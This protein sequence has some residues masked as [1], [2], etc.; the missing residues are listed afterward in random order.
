MIKSDW[1]YV[2][3]IFGAVLTSGVVVCLAIEGEFDAAAIVVPFVILIC[4][5][6]VMLIARNNSFL[7]RVMIAG[8]V[9]K[10]F[11]AWVYTAQASFEGT[12]ARWVYFETARQFSTSAI[13]MAYFFPLHHLWGTDL[14]IFIASHLFLL[15]GPSLAAAMVLFAMVSFW[16][17]FL[18]YCAFVKAFPA[19]DRR[20][21]AL[22]TFLFPSVVYWTAMLGK[23]APMLFAIGLVAYGVA[24]RFDAAGWFAIVLGSALASLIRPHIG[25]FLAI[26][27]FVTYIISD[28][29][30]RR[31]IIGLK[32]LLFPI[33]LVVCLSMVTYARQSL[34]LNSLEDAQARS[35]FA[36]EHDNVGGSAFGGEATP[37]ERFAGAPL[38]MFRPFPWE[39][40]NAS[41]LVASCEGLAL[42]IFV[43]RRRT[44]L[45]RLLRNARS[46]PLVV[47]ATCFFMIFSMVFSLSLSNFGLLARQR[48]MV[49]PLVL[50]LLV[51]AGPTVRRQGIRVR[52]R[53]A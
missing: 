35:D 22:A 30:Q 52:L 4:M 44:G 24:R 49:L 42:F 7:F 21:A 40:N 43:F 50:M 11:A 13:D 38:L 8:L 41:V 15:I 3:L 12:D 46:T 36:H 53:H 6:A 29:R 28:L 26:S 48:V 33:F 16:G 45:L 34:E 32:L 17:E 25:A 51:A 1:L 19:A 27:L 14:I 5:G 18:L 2:L 37:V 31:Q 10:L 20:L 23:D 9:A 39:A 47:F